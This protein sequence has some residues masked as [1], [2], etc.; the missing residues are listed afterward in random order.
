M[1]HLQMQAAQ[2]PLN[3]AAVIVLHEGRLDAGRRELLCMPGFH[4]EAAAVAEHLRLD[5]EH[6][7][8]RRVAKIH[9]WSRFK[10]G[11]RP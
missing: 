1:R 7:I 10:I 2:R 3:T 8:D 9:R 5:D 11:R 6:A 4:E